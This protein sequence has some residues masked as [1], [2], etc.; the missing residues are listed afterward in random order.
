MMGRG[1][2]SALQMLLSGCADNGA[3]WKI[4]T[5][6]T[7]KFSSRAVSKNVGFIHKDVCTF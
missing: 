2:S 7:V 3:L 5:V 4:C 6:L 1:E